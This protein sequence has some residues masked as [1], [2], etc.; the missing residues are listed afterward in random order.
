MRGR[1]CRISAA[2]AHAR[3]AGSE[4]LKDVFAYQVGDVCVRECV[5]VRASRRVSAGGQVR[6]RTLSLSQS[7]RCVWSLW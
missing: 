6:E 2:P 3:R 5:G 1:G 4:S 7:V